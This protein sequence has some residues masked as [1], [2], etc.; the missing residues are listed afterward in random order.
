MG[1]L[2]G[3]E[4][5]CWDIIGKATDQPV[6]NLLGGKLHQKL[7]SYSYLYPPEGADAETFYADPDASAEIA[8]RY[9]QEGFTAVKFDPAGAYT[10]LDPHMPSLEDIDRSEQFLRALRE[11]AGRGLICCLALMG[12]FLL[13]GQSGWRR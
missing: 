11:V 9:I 2:S 10:I 13:Q 3:L 5:A 6:H 4:I 12:N 7:R 1:V 8:E